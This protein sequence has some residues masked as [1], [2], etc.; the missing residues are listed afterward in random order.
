MAYQDHSQLRMYTT[1]R[2]AAT[3]SYVGG[4]FGL[5]T[6]SLFAVKPREWQIMKNGRSHGWLETAAFD[7][8]TPKEQ[9]PLRAEVYTA[10]IVRCIRVA[11]YAGVVWLVCKGFM[12]MLGI[13]TESAAERMRYPSVPPAIEDE[14]YKQVEVLKPEQPTTPASA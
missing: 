13:D 5:D 11:C 1:A 7:E 4:A 9:A 14:F 10:L 2:K 8:L 6:Y 12:V 3:L